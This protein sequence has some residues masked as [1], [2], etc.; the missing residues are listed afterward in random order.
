L[1]FNIGIHD[2]VIFNTQ[3][4]RFEKPNTQEKKGNASQK[5]RRPTTKVQ[6]CRA[7]RAQ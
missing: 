4:M 2:Y 3:N 6:F 7:C 5:Q 1:N